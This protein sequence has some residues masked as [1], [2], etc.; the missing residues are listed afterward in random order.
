MSHPT[1]LLVA[2]LLCLGCQPTDTAPSV[3]TTAPAAA[4]NI[5]FLLTDDQRHDMLGV[6]GNPILKTPHLDSLARNGTRFRNAYVTTAICSVSRASIL[7]GQYARRH[8]L[9]WF[10]RAFTDSSF[11]QTYPM[12]LREAGYA[13]GFIGKFGVNLDD[14]P[15][16]FD[17]WRG[18]GGQ[19]TYDHKNPDGSYLHLTR[20][21]GNQMAEFLDTFATGDRPFALSVSFKAP[22]VQHGDDPLIVFNHDPAYA[23][24]Y[25]NVEWAKPPQAEL[26]DYFPAEFTD[27]NEG[28]KRWYERFSTEER[29]DNSVEGYY[30]LVHGVDVQVG[31]L[32]DELRR[33]GLAENTVIVFT[34]D[35]GFYLGEYGLAGKWYGH[36]PSIRVPMIVYDPRPGA[37]RGQTS[38]RIALNIDVAPTLLDYAG[39]PAP[40][41]MQGRSL[42]PL[43]EGQDVDDWREDFLYEHLLPGP[44]EIPYYIP[45]TEGVVSVDEKYMDYFLGY[46]NDEELIEELYDLWRDSLEIDNLVEKEP[47]RAERLRGRMVVLRDKAR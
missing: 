23:N 47:E 7:S 36:E 8:D 28:R 16:Y 43:A 37:V 24:E 38:E 27:N 41:G 22:H 4:P 21:M 2:A 1:A 44:D 9:W 5:V 32:L 39:L 10:D 12:M 18:F 34:S 17:Y 29:Y 40:K 19:G 42:R 15:S 14:A 45:A 46:D 6:A 31:R 26:F 13:T 35:N 11:R 25:E 33:R 20:K 3:T 30:R